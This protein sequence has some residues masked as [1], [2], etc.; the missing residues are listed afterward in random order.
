M[1]LEF[2]QFVTSHAYPCDQKAIR[3]MTNNWYLR[4]QYAFEYC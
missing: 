2:M 4:P 3:T 1:R